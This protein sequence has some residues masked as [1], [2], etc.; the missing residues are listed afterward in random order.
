MALRD[1]LAEVRKYVFE[2]ATEDEFVEYLATPL[3]ETFDAMGFS[4]VYGES[5]R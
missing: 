1:K 3:P 5:D 2:E 4:R